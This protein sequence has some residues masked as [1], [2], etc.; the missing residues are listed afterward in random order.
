M[1]L[2]TET[3][4]L[5]VGESNVFEIDLNTD[6][7][8]GDQV[9]FTAKYSRLDADADAAIMKTRTGGGIV[10]LDPLVGK[11]Q[12]Q[13]TK[14]D[15]ENL[16]GRALVFDTKVKKVDQNPDLVQTVNKGVIILLNAVNVGAA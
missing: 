1:T 16:T 9:W 2:L 5:N 7:D 13:L 11:C 8:A 6:L 15:T 14:A 3:L 4:E 12:V 10:D